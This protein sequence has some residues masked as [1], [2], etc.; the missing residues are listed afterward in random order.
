M[1][2]EKVVLLLR[3]IFLSLVRMT[4]SIC[5]S[6]S[7]SYFHILTCSKWVK[8]LCAKLEVP[9]PTLETASTP[10]GVLCQLP[11]HPSSPKKTR[12]I[13]EPE[14]L[15]E[16]YNPRPYRME[17]HGA[18][19][20]VFGVLRDFQILS[21]EICT[22]VEAWL[23]CLALFLQFSTSLCWQLCTV[24]YLHRYTCISHSTYTL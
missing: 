17:D 12:R 15:Y 19:G 1:G 3:A 7:F 24:A 5:F 13:L 4:L 2:F 8:N 9:T 23:C 16:P 14:S 21:S 18:E 6:T 10:A 20:R 11:A 22:Y